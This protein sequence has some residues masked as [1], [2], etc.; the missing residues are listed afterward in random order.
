MPSAGQ[1]DQGSLTQTE[2]LPINLTIHSADAI[3]S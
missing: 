2:R 1:G 3:P